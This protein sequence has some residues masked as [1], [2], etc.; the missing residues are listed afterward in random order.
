MLSLKSEG[1]ALI[2][3]HLQVWFTVIFW[4]REHT[5]DYTQRVTYPALPCSGKAFT[6]SGAS[7][8]CYGLIKFMFHLE[9]FVNQVNVC[10]NLDK[11][12]SVINSDVDFVLCCFN[13]LDVC[14]VGE[15][16][17]RSKTNCEPCPDGQYNHKHSESKECQNCDPCGKS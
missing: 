4:K 3:H 15:K 6:S 8:A 9:S 11:L 2:V 10:Y 17:T 13:W 12:W 7:L 16:A 1:R 14:H 5:C